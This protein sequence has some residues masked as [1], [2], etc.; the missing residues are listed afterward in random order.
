M[1]NKNSNKLCG[2]KGLN[3]RSVTSMEVLDRLNADDINLVVNEGKHNK[4]VVSISEKLPR[5]KIFMVPQSFIGFGYRKSE[6]TLNYWEENA[7]WKQIATLPTNK[8]KIKFLTEIDKIQRHKRAKEFY[9]YLRVSSSKYSKCFSENQNNLIKNLFGHVGDEMHYLS[10]KQ[11]RAQ[12]LFSIDLNHKITIP[13]EINDFIERMNDTI[14]GFKQSFGFAFNPN[15]LFR[16]LIL[17]IIS[18]I[19]SDNVIDKGVAILQFLNNFDFADSLD[20]KEFATTLA[21]AIRGLQSKSEIRAQSR[22]DD[23]IPESLLVVLIKFITTIFN[24][25]DKYDIN[26]DDMR[27][28]RIRHIWSMVQS[29]TGLYNFFEKTFNVAYEYALSIVTDT[30]VGHTRIVKILPNYE[31]WFIRVTDIYH[32]CGVIKVKRSELLAKEVSELW[33]QAEDMLKSLS[34]MRAPSELMRVFIMKYNHCKELFDESRSLIYNDKPRVPPYTMYIYGDSGIGKST[35][36]PLLYNAIAKMEGIEGNDVAYVRVVNNEYWDNYHNQFCVI[37]DDIY[38]STAVEDNIQESMEIIRATNNMPFPLHM[39]NLND[40]GNTRFD[41]KLLIMT[42]NQ[43]NPVET[44][45]V[46]KEAV[47]R[48]RDIIVHV[49]V[50]D[51]YSFSTIIDGKPVRKIKEGLQSLETKIYLFDIHDSMGTCCIFQSLEWDELLK[52]VWFNYTSKMQR[53]TRILSE[54]QCLVDKG[55]DYLKAQSLIES[56]EYSLSENKNLKTLIIPPEDVE[57]IFEKDEQTLFQTLI[58]NKMNENVLASK[59]QIDRFKIFKQRNSGERYLPIIKTW[60]DM[61]FGWSMGITKTISA[62]TTLQSMLTFGAMVTTLFGAYKLFTACTTVTS[63]AASGDNKTPKKVN[64]VRVAEAASGDNKTTKVLRSM[65]AGR[66]YKDVHSLKAE[67]STDIN[68]MVLSHNVL[69]YN[70]FRFTIKVGSTASTSHGIF[71]G[72]RIAI[73]PMHDL[74]MLSDDVE[75]TVSVFTGGASWLDI[76]TSVIDVQHYEEMDVT[77][78]KFPSVIPQFKNIIHHFIKETDLGKFDFSHLRILTTSVVPVKNNQVVYKEESYRNCKLQGSVEYTDVMCERITVIKSIRYKAETYAGL[79][80]SPLMLMNRYCARKIC[81]FHVAGAVGI[82]YSNV[83]VQENLMKYFNMFFEDKLPIEIEAPILEESD[84][85]AQSYILDSDVVEFCGVVEPSKG[86]WQPN[87]T[88]IEPSI[89]QGEW[90]P[91]VTQPAILSI[92]GDLNPYRNGLIK[93]FGS[94]RYL[95]QSIL[96]DIVR[97]MI[98]EINTCEDKHKHILTDAQALNGIC[99][100]DYIRPMKLSTSAGYPYVLTKG[101]E[102]GK[103]SFVQIEDDVAYYG[104]LLWKECQD[105]ENKA[106]QGIVKETIWIDNLKDERRPIQKVEQG[107]TRLFVSAPFDFSIMF[108]KYFLSFCAHIMRNRDDLESAVGINPHSK[109][110]DIMFRKLMEVDET[111][112]FIVGDYS[113]YDGTI[114]AQVIDCVKVIV[115]AWYDDGFDLQREVLFSSIMYPYHIVGRS[116]YRVVRGNPSGNPLTTVLNSLVNTILMR[117]AW[118][119]LAKQHNM[120]LSHYFK[121]VRAKNYGDDNILCV[122][123][124]VPWFSYEALVETFKRMGLD[125][126]KPD[127]GVSG[128]DD[129]T[130]LKRAFRYDRDANAYMPALNLNS[131]NELINWVRRGID[132][133]E[134]LMSNVEDA[135]LEMFY[136]GKQNYR[137]FTMRLQQ[138]LMRNK[139]PWFPETWETKYNK[140]ISDG[141]SA[142]YNILP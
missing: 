92:R 44:G 55:C 35:I 32:D 119:V 77:F 25:K 101:K 128:Y 91:I 103:R 114:P 63:E 123:N 127:K 83:L 39:A 48:R 57:F 88:T 19:R 118:V 21:Q 56:A 14:E 23:T 111:H 58:D 18:L 54:M 27:V 43:K 33:I 40:K 66:M 131:I 104:D 73:V 97:T 130:F 15:K 90:T 74:A 29:M 6:G 102:K 52:L 11:I 110:W 3:G 99:D 47:L 100:D 81:G 53:E 109:E 93:Y 68:S 139:I 105:R 59:R 28:K 107:K 69:M 141:F 34:Q 49:R 76:D 95:D 30:P 17:T 98:I 61:L 140:W 86:V 13:S 50:K 125:Y 8:F 67:S 106:A 1:S 135:T 116:V 7:F 94:V 62:N 96:D 126:N 20:I 5:L 78:L 80:G 133:Q 113:C 22:I 138:A 142:H 134:A 120:D 38:Q 121:Y 108:R 117:Y 124:Q 31:Q 42:S 51:E 85:K 75:S 82:G 64:M 2:G 45:V 12:G 115:N 60:K 9:T 71:L 4:H 112:T 79:C 132:R 84:L 41:S 36:T 122:S 26:M 72:D 24:H 46:H 136:H 37:Y 89:M 10:D 70:V 65:K 16:S 137:D 87:N 129:V